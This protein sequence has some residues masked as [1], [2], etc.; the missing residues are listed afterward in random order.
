MDRTEFS[1][2]GSHALDLIRVAS[3][4][5]MFERIP[6]IGFML[7]VVGVLSGFIAFYISLDALPKIKVP[8]ES[9]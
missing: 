7:G 1:N 4:G 2:C 5:P 8:I 9:L 3:G 6:V